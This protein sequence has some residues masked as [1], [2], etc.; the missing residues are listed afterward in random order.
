M[1]QHK[2][3]DRG[4]VVITALGVSEAAYLS[5]SYT[6]TPGGCPSASFLV[7]NIGKVGASILPIGQCSPWRYAP[8]C[9]ILFRAIVQFVGR[10]SHES[11]LSMDWHSFCCP[12]L[13]SS[14][15]HRVPHGNYSLAAVSLQSRPICA[16]IVVLLWPFMSL[17]IEKRWTRAT[18]E[19]LR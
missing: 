13:V 10:S 18:L 17:L 12:P 6:F 7:P 1:L 9:L 5:P 19:F 4:G 11:A 14:I 15:G 16:A 8:A 3:L 2:E